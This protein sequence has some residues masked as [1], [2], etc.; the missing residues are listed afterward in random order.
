MDARPDPRATVRRWIAIIAGALFS[1]LAF[2]KW[3][4]IDRALLNVLGFSA[5]VFVVLV[6]LTYRAFDRISTAA[7]AYAERDASGDQT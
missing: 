2:L 5:G 6:W 1:L 7:R 4:E 3:L